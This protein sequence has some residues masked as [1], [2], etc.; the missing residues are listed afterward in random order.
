MARSLSHTIAS[1][2]E[3]DAISDYLQQRL[4][5]LGLDDVPAVEA[6]AWPDEANLLDDSRSRPGLPLRNLLRAGAIPGAE[7]RPP[8]PHGRW[9]VM[10]EGRRG[11]DARRQHRRQQPPDQART[12]AATP[13]RARPDG[14]ES[15]A[16]AD[17]LTR[18]ALAARG[19]RGFERFKD[20][21][22]DCVPTGAGVYVV[23]REAN[24][25]PTF[26]SRNPAGWFKGLDPTVPVSELEA[27]WPE[28]AQCVYIGKAD[29][30]T[31]G[32]RGLRVR[33]K[34]FRQYADGQAVGH[35]G[36]RRIWQL[37]DSDDFVIAWLPTPNADPGDLEAEL[38]NSFSA[39]HDKL[40]IGNRTLGRSQRS[41]TSRLS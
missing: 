24:H 14:P 39:E 8:I 35:Q 1:M 30:G 27:S 22:L 32:Q 29:L 31:R 37:A 3:A 23:L 6:A 13:T 18:N 11:T 17:A 16:A 40:P 38:I 33:I 21:A 15:G 12:A 36:G 10:R 7:Q 19:F 26:L 34:E 4:H 28:G 41:S 20:L 5:H 2:P 25:R 9:F